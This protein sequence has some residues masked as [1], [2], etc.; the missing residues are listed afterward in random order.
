MVAINV[1]LEVD[2]TGQVCADSLGTQF[3]SGIGGQVDFNRG[4]ARSPGGKAIIALPSTAKD[5][6]VSRIVTRL[7]PGAGVV[8]TRGDVHYV[9]TEYGVAYL[10]GKSVQER[11]MA[12]ITIAHPEVPRPAAAGRPS[13]PS[14][15]ARSWR[16]SRARSSSGPTEFRTT[17]VLRR[18]HADQLPPDPSRPTS[19]ACATCSTRCRRKRSTTG[20]CPA[21]ST[22]RA[23]R[24]Q[25]FVYIDHRKRRRHRRHAARGAR[26]G[27]HRHRPLLPRP[28]D[29][30]GGSGLRRAGRLAEPRHRHVPAEAPGHASPSATASAA[31]PPR[32]CARIARCSSVFLTSDFKVRSEPNEDV[33]S[34]HMYFA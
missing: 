33:F 10:H 21:R 18:R 7:S 6:T 23:S 11:A 16:T 31:S 12:L 14:T 9:V 8:T 19:R 20:S 22:F 30:P 34:F 17:Y 2:L 26:R 24:F 1:A 25:D 4:A 13:R 27:H 29:Q 15:C 28:E 5:G 32:C 3:Y